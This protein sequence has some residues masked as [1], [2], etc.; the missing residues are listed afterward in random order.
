MRNFILA[1]AL[2]LTAGIAS[3]AVV[4]DEAEIDF[5]NGDYGKVNNYYFQV[6]E[7]YPVYTVTDEETQHDSYWRDFR[8]V[9]KTVG[10]G[11]S[12]DLY[13]V[14]KVIYTGHEDY[15]WNTVINGEVDEVLA[16]PVDGLQIG[17]RVMKDDLEY[18]SF[19]YTYEGNTNHFFSVKNATTLELRDD[20][21]NVFASISFVDPA[22]KSFGQPLPTPVTTL[23]IA[24]GFGAAFMMYRNRRQTVKG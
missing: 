15:Y 3:A 7:S 20:E 4:H 1:A 24:L 17:V 13:D 6:P 2:F 11:Y 10:D 19:T 5:Y 23:L 14:N 21:N 8:I 16:I 9:T 22:D 18:T 12:F